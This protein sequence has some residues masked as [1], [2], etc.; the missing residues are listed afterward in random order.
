MLA[1]CLVMALWVV[2]HSYCIGLYG[3]ATFKLSPSAFLEV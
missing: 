2:V 1:K 3:E